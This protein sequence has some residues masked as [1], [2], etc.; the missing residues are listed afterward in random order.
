MTVTQGI[1]WGPEKSWEYQA[2]RLLT[3][4]CCYLPAWASQHTRPPISL[5]RVSSCYPS[6]DKYYESSFCT[7]KHRKKAKKKEKK[8][9]LAPSGPFR[10]CEGYRTDWDRGNG[11]RRHQG[12]GEGPGFLSTPILCPLT[13]SCIALLGCRGSRFVPRTGATWDRAVLLQLD[14][15]CRCNAWDEKAECDKVARG[16][17]RSSTASPGFYTH[18]QTRRVELFDKW[19]YYLHCSMRL[20]WY[21]LSLSKRCLVYS[22]VL[23]YIHF[24][25]QFSFIHHPSPN[26]CT[27]TLSS[28]HKQRAFLP[29]PVFI[30]MP[31]IDLRP[32]ALSFVSTHGVGAYLFRLALQLLHHLKQLCTSLY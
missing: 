28:F 13:P 24:H 23:R 3:P 32:A 7:S 26:C 8:K 16:R 20:L 14:S 18:P 25:F 4:D 12:S 11:A 17:V 19:I 5:V 1:S 2:H 10:G 21:P 6:V 30:K 31:P 15:P 29:S 22:G 9:K 27:H